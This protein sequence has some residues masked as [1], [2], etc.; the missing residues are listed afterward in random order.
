M[1]VTTGKRLATVEEKTA[2][3]TPTPTPR[4]KSTWLE[5][6]AAATNTM[7]KEISTP[8]LKTESKLWLKK[9]TEVLMRP[10]K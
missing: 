6:I 7:F 5:M 3:H 8:K 1:C 2:A 4:M 10:T 9:S